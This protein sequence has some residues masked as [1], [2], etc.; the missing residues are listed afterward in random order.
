MRRDA[1]NMANP[2]ISPE[3]EILEREQHVP[4]YRVVL[5]DDNDHTYDYVIEMLQ[6]IFIFTLDQAYRHAEEVD[7]AGRT[8]LITCE[9]RE[10]EYARD[11]IHAYGPD[12]RLPRS[13]GSMSA[14][15]EPAAVDWRH[16]GYH[17]N[18][19]FPP[20][21][22]L[23]AIGVCMMAQQISQPSPVQPPAQ[24]PAAQQPRMTAPDGTTLPL[25]I[26]PPPPTLPAD[27]VV[28][29]VGGIEITAGQLDQ[30]LDAYS[31]TQRVFV[32][33]PGR[34]QFIDQLVR[35]L[36]LSQEAKRRK[37]DQ[38]DRYRNQLAYSSAGILSSHAEEDIRKNVK[39]D[40]A[41]LQEY[42]TAHPLDYMQLRARHILIRMQGASIA[43]RPGQKDLTDA[44]A[45]ANARE[46]RKKIDGGADFAEL[47][48]N[49]IRRHLHE[50]QWRRPGFLQARTNAALDSRK[51]RSP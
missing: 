22:F 42:L 41:M 35:V 10:A 36:T 49:G 11:Q 34:Q 3:T 18:M 46:L 37:L 48:A 4:L 45:L 29:R 19:R 24:P 14:V 39:I 23:A 43:L 27:R 33:G 9:L 1:A 8:V 17:T 13:K 50:R 21:L 44:E 2:A 38:T 40:D 5:L 31:E 6:K 15:V 25:E 30:I 32:N 47:A 12:W 51:R 16:V 26:A 20:V 7:R 28:V